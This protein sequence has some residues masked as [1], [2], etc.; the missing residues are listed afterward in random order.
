MPLFQS[1]FFNLSTYGTSFFFC[2]LQSFFL[3]LA[4]MAPLFFCPYFAIFFFYKNNLGLQ[5]FEGALLCAAFFRQ[6][7]LAIPQI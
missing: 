3:T 7:P 5:A 2:P 1:F 4:L 6:I